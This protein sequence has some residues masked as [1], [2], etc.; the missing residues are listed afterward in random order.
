MST[1]PAAVPRW[2]GY[3][4]LPLLNL[5]A[6]LL[7][8]GLVVTVLGESPWT[9]MEVL[10][11]GAF[12]DLESLGFTL[13]Y[14]TSFIFA[15]LAVSVA[16][17]CGLFNIGVEGQAYIGG[18]G[19][20]LLC[21]A[22]GS[23]PFLIVLPLALLAAMLFGA[24]WAF[25]PGWLQA[26]RGSHVV[27]TTIMFNFIAAALMTYLLVDVLIRPG[28]QSPE[29]RE[30][31]EHLWL[32]TARDML[33]VVGVAMPRSPLNFSFVFA[34]LAAVAV[35]VY[36]WHT[37]WGY[38]LRAVGFNE[39]AARY[40]GI[41]PAR[42][43]IIAMA[44]SGGLAGLV[45]INELLGVHHRL[46]MDFPAGYGFIGIAVALMG[47]NHPLGVC[48]SALLFGALFQGGTEISF[49]MPRLNREMVVVIEGLVILFC[50]A[51]RWW[52]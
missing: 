26:K 18:L 40:A 5:F 10:V 1:G 45:A 44:V 14:T 39:E 4:L 8:S 50:G 30:F 13:Y 36:I 28:Q 33:A 25:I 17:H 48:L 35:W 15:G 27:I 41:A 19:A 32:P 6:A 24:A 42:H 49:D 2:V 12:G 46:L 7:L 51:A 31:A 21:L 22:L 38:E 47:R 34:L 16:F 37:R 20:T 3:V 9:L 11:S 43:I 29:S 23:W 52:W